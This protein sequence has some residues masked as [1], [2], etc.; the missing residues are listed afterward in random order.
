MTL[1]TDRPLTHAGLSLTNR[2][3]DFF[4]HNH[5]KGRV[6][7]DPPYQRGSVWTDDQRRALIY[8]WLT[9]T[10]IPAVV[11]NDRR[12]AGW[13]RGRDFDRRP[14]MYA[15]IDGRQ[16]IETAVEWFTG[17]LYV[18]ASWFEP[19]YVART[20]DLGDGPYV[21][22]EGLSEVGQR[23]TE[24][25]TLPCAEGQLPTLKAE[26]DLYLLV[27]GGGTPQNA[28]DMQRAADVAANAD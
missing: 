20:G 21:S 12:S 14:P 5:G 7:L 2:P 10:P 22:F 6:L 3:V 18:P 27:N 25:F 15:V 23:L 8:S 4:V 13:Y 28:A 19:A 24:N 9:G 17:R 16:R 11:I 1:Q 26:A